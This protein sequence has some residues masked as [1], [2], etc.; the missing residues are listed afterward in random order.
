MC[1]FD[2]F[3]S[4]SIIYQFIKLVNNKQ[5]LVPFTHR[6]KA[7]GIVQNEDEDM[8]QQAIDNHV[9]LLICPDSASNDRNQCHELHK[10]GIDVLI[11]DHHEITT[12]PREEDAILINHHLA[13]EKLN[14]HLSGCGVTF[15]FVQ[16][17]AKEWNIDIGNLYYD[18]VASSLATDSC[19]MLA[20]E[21]YAITVHGFKHL[22]NPMLI[23]M[24]EEFNRR[25]ATPEGVSWGMGSR[26]NA[27][28]RS[29]TMEDKTKLFMAL[30]GEGD[31]DEAIDIAKKCHTEGSKLA[32]NLAKEIE[33]TA[34]LN[35]KVVVGFSN[36][37]NKNY[38]GLI[39]NKV[40][41]KYNKPTLILRDIGNKYGGSLR[42]PA[43]IADKINESGYANCQGHLAASGI[44]VTQENLPK[45]IEWFDKSDLDM[46]P[47]K[48]VAG[49]LEPDKV[50]MSICKDCYENG[51]IWAKDIVKPVFYMNLHT[52]PGDI[53]VCGKKGNTVRINNQ[54]VG[55][56]KMTSRA[57]D[58][59]LITTQDCEVE[60][61]VSLE[62][63]EYGGNVSPQAKVEE[64]EITPVV[65]KEMDW[66]D[67]F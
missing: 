20:P 19:S 41:S 32:T 44:E 47:P 56:I 36:A 11:L 23:R 46:N 67:L 24:F 35:H 57:E 10:H 65:K 54:G 27:V 15:K 48:P 9:Q 8:V 25:G 63:N 3:S 1:D 38:S 42:S 5:V 12:P 62:V 61:L 59:E 31:I 2:G 28:I 21:N 33:K 13:P 53:Y 58:R 64:W 22:T 4:A 49:V 16:A 37:E 14:I 60:L 17:C 6:F 18:L 26:V 66:S 40:V 29:G 45:L 34:D 43:D 51:L 7:H 52:K 50:N 39:A 30:V 55:I